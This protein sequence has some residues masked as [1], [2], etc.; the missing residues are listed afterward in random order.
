MHRPKLD[1][2]QV[3]WVLTYNI[4]DL[5]HI[6]VQVTH[7]TGPI[8]KYKEAM[9]P[10]PYML[11]WNLWVWSHTAYGI[12]YYDVPEELK[13]LYLETF[14]YRLR[15]RPAQPGF[16]SLLEDQEELFKL[17]LELSKS[18]KTEEWT[19]QDLDEALKELKTGE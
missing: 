9:G 8:Y 4:W 15:H 10:V 19:M 16:E 14:K 2:G 1:M 6:Y 11:I 7:G 18:V 17:R 5:S 12:A 3:P 13:K